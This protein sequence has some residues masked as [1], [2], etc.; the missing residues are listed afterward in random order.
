VADPATANDP[1]TKRITMGWDRMARKAGMSDKAAKRN[2][3]LLIKKLAVELIASEDSAT[4]TGRT[5][6]VYSFAAILQR[7][8]AAGMLYVVRDKG[9][10]FLTITEVETFATRQTTEPIRNVATVDIPSTVDKT[11]TVMGDKTST[12]TGD[13]T[14][15]PLRRSLR[16]KEKKTT[17]TYMNLGPIVE[18]LSAYVMADESAAKQIADGSLVACEDATI[19]EI[20]SVIH[21]K[22]PTIFRNRSTQNPLGLLIHAVPQCFE[23]SGILQLR[24]HWAA[25]KERV[26]AR[27]MERERQNREFI[28]LAKRERSRCEATL[29]NPASTEKQK[30]A[31]AKQ[32]SDVA[33]Y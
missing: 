24:R 1:D 21:E 27:E 28:E 12:D 32:L 33:G 17:T 3:T 22:S 30:A 31:A 14:S 4:R 8:A 19:E 15:T 23:G 10:R 7:R 16:S 26:V 13:K 25:E 5:Y 29:A 20:V 9:V 11:S 2:L 6:R 18:A